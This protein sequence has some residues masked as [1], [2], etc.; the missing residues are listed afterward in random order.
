MGLGYPDLLGYFKVRLGNF[1]AS[2]RTGY[3]VGW[4]TLAAIISDLEVLG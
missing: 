2:L 3:H 4:L 1:L